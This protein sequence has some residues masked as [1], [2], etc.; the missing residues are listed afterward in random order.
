MII[1]NLGREQDFFSNLFSHAHTNVNEQTNKTKTKPT[2]N[3]KQ[4]KKKILRQTRVF[5][6][7]KYTQRLYCRR[8]MQIRLCCKPAPDVVAVVVSAAAAAAAGVVT[9][10][11]AANTA[12][13]GIVKLEALGARGQR[14]ALGSGLHYQVC[15]CQ[16]YVAADNDAA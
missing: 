2:T 6:S 9:A 7:D 12:V 16:D 14:C 1:L 15:C 8:V 4:K 13:L 10:T 5:N 3:Q 11:I